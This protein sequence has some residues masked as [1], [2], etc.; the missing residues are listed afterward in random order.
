MEQVGF[1]VTVQHPDVDETPRPGEDGL[2][3]AERL[4]TAKAQASVAMVGSADHG[5]TV[6]LAADTVVW[7]DACVLGKPADDAD[8]CAML[9]Q[10][11]GGTHRVT[12]GFCVFDAREPTKTTTRSVTTD[13]TFHDLSDAQIAAYVTTGEPIGKAGAYAIQGMGAVLV[14]AIAGSYSNVVGLP[15]DAVVNTMRSEG[16]LDTWPWEFSNE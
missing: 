2:A 12:T 9:R 16:Y 8:A 4:A 14:R 15:I 11:S 7:N 10:L 13:V 5:A 1:C 3:L 6:G